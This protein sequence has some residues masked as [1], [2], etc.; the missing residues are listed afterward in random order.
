MRTLLARS[1]LFGLVAVFS[2]PATVTTARRVGV[3]EHTGN[4]PVRG[5]NYHRAVF[6]NRGGT[7]KDLLAFKARLLD[8]GA[9]H[10][11]A[12][13]PS[14]IVCDLP[15]GVSEAALAAAEGMELLPGVLD[16][17][18]GPGSDSR[19]FPGL[20]EI[21]R[22]YSPRASVDAKA[23]EPGIPPEDPGFSDKVLRVPVRV[24][25]KWK[26]Q[27]AASSPGEVMRNPSQNSEFMMGEILVQVIFPESDGGEENWS[28][29]R[30]SDAISG[31]YSAMLDFQEEYSIYPIDLT[32]RLFQR[33]RTQFEP[34]DH[35]DDSDHVWINDVMANMGYDVSKGDP[36]LIVH[37]FNEDGRK[38]YGTN[39]VFTA[40]VANSANAPGH[41]FKDARYTAYAYLGGPYLVIPYPA[42]SNPYGIDQV[43]LFSQVFQHET[44]HIF[45]ALDEYK[46]AIGDCNAHSGYLDY[47]NKNKILEVDPY[48]RPTGCRDLDYCIMAQAKQ[49]LG[50]PICFFTAGMM[51]VVDADDNSVPDLYQST[52]TVIFENSSA[53]TLLASDVTV[54][55]KAVSVPVENRNPAQPE[56]TRID[57]AAPLQDGFLSV[58]GSGNIILTPEDG[59]W[60]EPEEDLV[61]KLKSIPVGLTEV[62]IKV[63]TRVGISSGVI[64]KRI[65]NLGLKYSLFEVKVANRGITLEWRMFGET[66]GAR[67]DLYRVAVSP[68]EDTLIVSGLHPSGV[69]GD[70]YTPYEFTDTTVT[71]GT[72]YRYFVRGTFGLDF[73]GGTKVFTMD[74]GTVEVTAML[75]MH[76]GELV[77]NAVPNPFSGS[78]SFSIFIPP[79]YRETGPPTGG[80][81]G[82]GRSASLVEEVPTRVD[83]RIYDVTGRLVKIVYRDELRSTVVT[84]SW[85]GRNDRGETVSSGI[86][87]LRAAAGDRVQVKKLVLLR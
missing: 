62:G 37:E 56:E 61:V 14:Y 72:K 25:K 41:L 15:E 33:A 44:C 6:F 76:S 47:Y 87:F 81:R 23:H 36:I 48:G 27:A 82:M 58:S 45:W 63:R 46:S 7:E 28:D 18:A 70:G 12:F 53:E 66:F 65:Y 75:P 74:S 32:F 30:L 78:T 83:V 20:R 52:P 9:V 2:L 3:L 73:H 26:P 86:Y 51:G 55:C 13:L 80:S 31:V 24:M 57:Y 38:H 17:A 64:T 43:L 22:A 54:R 10:V 4:I 69:A 71:P 8:A 29:A 34:I 21:G 11:N 67:F 49:D 84:T 60:D 68:G 1:L 59:K 35:N 42:G 77:S 79:S 85:D 50:R 39:W 40:F 16:K 19:F 5:M